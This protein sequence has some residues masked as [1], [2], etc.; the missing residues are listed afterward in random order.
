MWY[1][2]Q[3]FPGMYG[4]WKMLHLL[5]FELIYSLITVTSDISDDAC[6]YR[7]PESVFA[8][9]CDLS[10]CDFGYHSYVCV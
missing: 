4:E 3:V 5:L 2:M 8:V 9:F 7:L 1:I 10:V 6:D